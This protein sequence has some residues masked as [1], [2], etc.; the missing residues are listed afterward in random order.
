MAGL[1]REL[2]VHV[3]WEKQHEIDELLD[4]VTESSADA[5]TP[6]ESLARPT[7]ADFGNERR[8]DA[9]SAEVGSDNDVDSIDQALLDSDT[10]PA[11]GYI[12]RNS[13]IH[14]MRRLHHQGMSVE[15]AMSRKSSDESVTQKQTSNYN[16]YLDDENVELDMFADPL[17][18]PPYE[19]AK[20]LLDSY[21]DTVQ[22]TFPIL[23]K[24]KLIAEFS[25]FY[26]SMSST[27][28]VLVSEKTHA[29]WNLIFAIGA[30]YS[31]LVL[32]E[33]P[34]A[35]TYSCLSPEYPI[36]LT[37]IA[38]RDHL[39]YHSRAWT[40][41]QRGP[42]WCSH[43][44]LPQVQLTG[45]LSLYYLAIG[46]VNRSVA[47]PPFFYLERGGLISLLSNLPICITI[48]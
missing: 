21:M 45:L 40:L 3:E 9:R 46:R 44:D 8:D 42:W 23:D 30:I 24:A 39:V 12:G 14:L 20:R 19:V 13:D 31:R 41:M 29:I 11:I 35:G 7:P 27:A 18:L 34:A 43:P 32:P 38:A 47:P 15:E 48:S 33:W 4:Q 17:Q 37:L 1:L 16:F 5:S 26:A 36:S 28:P 6:T 22:N 10:P 25:H 2:R